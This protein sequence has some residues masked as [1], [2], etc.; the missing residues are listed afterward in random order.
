MF[1][2]DMDDRQ[3]LSDNVFGAGTFFPEV[4]GE[5]GPQFKLADFGPR[6]KEDLKYFNWGVSK[7]EKKKNKEHN[8]KIAF[9]RKMMVFVE[10]M[11]NYIY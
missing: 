10:D 11:V 3:Y 2:Y 8:K 5:Y 4:R 9:K 6:Y 1:D 7:E